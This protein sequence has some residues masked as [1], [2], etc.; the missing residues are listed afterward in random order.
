[1]YREMNTSL[2]RSQIGSWITVSDTKRNNWCSGNLPTGVLVITTYPP[3][4]C[5]IATFSQDLVLA[6]NNKFSRSFKIS[7]CALE[8]DTEQHAYPENVKYALNTDD[9]RQFDSL[10]VSINNDA[11]IR[12][13]LIQHEFGLFRNNE[14]KFRE[15]LTNITKPIII[16]FHTVLPDPDE[17]LRVKVS[18]MA[19]EAQSIIVMTNSSADI[20]MRDY[21]IFSEKIEVIPHGTHLVPHGDKLFLKT[22]YQL[23]GRMVLSTF[24]LL[25]SG[26]SIETTLDALPDIVERNPSVL[27]LIIGKTHPS[28]VKNEGEKYRQMLMHKVH[29]LQLNDHVRFINQFLPLPDLLEYLQL[30]DIYLFTS[31][32]PYQ[33]VSGTFSYAISCGCPIISTPIPHALEVLDNDTG[34]IIDF[35]SSAQL[36]TAVNYLISDEA[37]RKEMISNGLHR[38]ASTAWE[39]AAIAHALLFEKNTI[40]PLSLNYNIPKVNLDHLK[41]MTT[42]LGIIQ[43]SRLNQPDIDSGYTLDDNA[44]ALIAMCRY[45]ELRKESETLTYIGIYLSVVRY[46]QQGD[47]RFL[48]YVDENG[49]FT[50]QNDDANLADANGRAVWALGYLVSLRELLPVAL[51]EEAISIIQKTLPNVVRVYSTRAMAFIIKGLYYSNL[52]NED[53]TCTV[54][55]SL[56][57]DRLLQMYRHEAS[58]K[59]RW[60][61]SYLT[62]GNSLLP[63]AML[64]AWLATGTLEYKN[65]AKSSFDFLITKIF[66]GNTIKAI[67]NKFWLIRGNEKEQARLGGEQPIEIAYTIMALDKFINVF[68]SLEYLDKLRN[69]FSWFLGNNHLHRIV[70]NPCTGGCYDGLEEHNVNLNQGAESTLSYLISR[71]IVAKVAAKF[72]ASGLA[73]NDRVGQSFSHAHD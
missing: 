45:Y 15:L 2:E 67:S 49:N 65:I 11:S 20:L 28:I 3:R 46:C 12:M 27:F 10:A 63:E 36:S 58:D 40:F 52:K 51:V 41:K 60:F 34:I 1:M 70:Y 13:V 14:R 23:A 18:Q 22:K 55:I 35:N 26:K 16:V 50:R 39:N 5:G 53:D 62:Y 29:V 38:M 33:A 21:K 24:G 25:S 56:L 30:T 7:I 57:A 72:K 44:R 32:D 4:E 48:N 61:E 31:N 68:N 42:P 71:L 8:S 17:M 37:R 9:P 69:A 54:L 19:D 66:D 59:W 47:G 64:C 6:L 73:I 43:F